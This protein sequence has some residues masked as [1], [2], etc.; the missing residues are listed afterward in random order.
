MAKI[1]VILSYKKRQ[2]LKWF[3]HVKWREITNKFRAIIE[4]QPEGKRPWR[5]QKK[6]C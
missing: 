6:K 2:R 3:R 1:L 4:W 5:R